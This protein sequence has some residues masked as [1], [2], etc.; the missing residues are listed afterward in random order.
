MLRVCCVGACLGLPV[1]S[2]MQV[3]D[4]LAYPMRASLTLQLA[5]A[6][7]RHALRFQQLQVWAT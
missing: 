1:L 2:R 7:V 3:W 4:T 6:H 5:Q